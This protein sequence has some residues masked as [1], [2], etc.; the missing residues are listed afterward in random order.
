M[1]VCFDSQINFMT[2]SFIPFSTKIICLFLLKDLETLSSTASLPND[3]YPPKFYFL[4]SI[5]W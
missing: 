2:S 5:L 1:A 3:L 4:A